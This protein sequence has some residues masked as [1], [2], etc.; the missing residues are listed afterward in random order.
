VGQVSP[1]RRP[2]WPYGRRLAKALE[3]L[4][5]P[6][7]DMLIDHEIDFEDLPAH[8]RVLAETNRPGLCTVVRYN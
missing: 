1:G 5:D 8:M 6:V 3:L 2:R 4:C 7:I